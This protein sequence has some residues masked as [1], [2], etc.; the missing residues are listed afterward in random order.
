MSVISRK[1]AA[2]SGVMVFRS[3]YIGF[4]SLTFASALNK[5]FVSSTCFQRID[6][7]STVSLI[8][9]GAFMSAS[10]FNKI[11]IKLMLL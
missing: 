1:E 7:V 8:C 10:E 3:L 2:W 6:A 5:N 4:Q 9:A 11:C